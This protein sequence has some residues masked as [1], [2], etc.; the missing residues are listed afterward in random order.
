[1]EQVIISMDRYQKLKEF[2]EAVQSDSEDNFR[3]DL[4]ILDGLEVYPVPDHPGFYADIEAGKIYNSNTGKWLAD[5]SQG[6]KRTGY[7]YVGMKDSKG[8]YVSMNESWAVF[9][10]YMGVTKDFFLDKGMTLHHINGVKQDN[11]YFNL[12]PIL[13]KHQYR[14][15]GTKKRIK[16]RTTRRITLSEKDTLEAAWET[17]EEPKRSEFVNEWSEKLDIHWRTLD[18][19]VKKNFLGDSDD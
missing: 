14:D 18:N 4:L 2:E 16:N 15:S 6:S 12:M 11:S 3:D 8:N 9:T 10:A 1:M 7:V 17:C 13:H 19:Y 5:G